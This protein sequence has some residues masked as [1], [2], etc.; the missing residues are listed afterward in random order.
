MLNV[1]QDREAILDTLALYCER[2]D[3]YDIAN[4]AHCFAVD[5]VADYGPGRGGQIAGREAI[6]ARIASGQRVF[7]HTHHQLGQSRIQIRGDIATA[8]TYVTA[9][10]ERFTGEREIVC[11]RYRDELRRGTSAWQITRREI[12][13]ALVQ[14]FPGVEWNWV[15]RAAAD[16]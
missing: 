13:V 6:V 9:W 10:H 15:K 5:A 11:L 12:E 14:G 1:P 2:L 8:L 4:V 16:G 3:E 7:R